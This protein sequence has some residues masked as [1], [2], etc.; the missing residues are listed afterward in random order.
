MCL[1][2]LDFQKQKMSLLEAR[3]AFGEMRQSMEPAHVREVLD[4][5]DK[6]EEEEK[7][8]EEEEA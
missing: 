8:K 1:I 2:C 6:A 4:M 5:L 3:R 7:E